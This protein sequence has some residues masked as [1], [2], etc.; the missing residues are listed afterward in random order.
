MKKAG[1]IILFRFPQTDLNPGKPRPALLL[2]RL[3][4]RRGRVLP[5]GD[6]LMCMIST[7]TR[8]YIPGF[9][10]LLTLGDG[11]SVRV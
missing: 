9:D 4:G 1:Q 2:G 11:D 8:H 6:W 5:D 3:P 7:Q 10:E